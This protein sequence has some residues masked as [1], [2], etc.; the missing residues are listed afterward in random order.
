MP[1]TRFVGGIPTAAPERA[2]LDACRGLT[3]LRDIR[4]LLCEAVQRGLTTPVRLLSALHQARWQGSKAI[5]R[6]LADLAAGCRSAPECELRDLVRRSHTLAEPRWNQPLP[7][8]E[9]PIR[10]DACW[11]DAR[12]VD[13]IDSAEW[14]RFG[15]RVEETERRRSRLASLGWTVVPVSPRRLR[16]EPETVLKEIEA[17]VRA[18]YARAAA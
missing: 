14:H 6:A 4:A 2:V 8:V 9:P 3:S 5:R 11:Q 12:V 1:E 18:G 10:P 15:D 7:D 17:A 13:E 16:E